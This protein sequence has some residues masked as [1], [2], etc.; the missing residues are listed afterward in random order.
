[1]SSRFVGVAGL[2]R[3]GSTLLCQLLAEHPEIHC[4]GHSSPL[5]NALLA[6]RRFISDDQ[7]MLSQLDV[8]FDKTYQ[9]L[10]SAMQG[11]LKGWYADSGKPVTVD[12]NRAWLHCIEMVLQLDP[13]ARIL[14]P[15]RELGQIYGSIE[16]QHQKTILLDFIDHLADFDRFGRADQ[17]FAADKSIGAPLSSIRAVED[18]PQETKSRLYF[19]KFEDMVANPVETM[20]H[21]FAWLGVSPRKIDPKNLTVRP[22]ESD[23]HYRYKYRHRQQ[24]KFSPPKLHQIPPRIQKRIETA[25]SWYYDWFYPRAKVTRA[26]KP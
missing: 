13:E 3:A 12:K 14:V 16:A 18:L 1:M 26:R 23:S 24:S 5:C 25:C 4:E 2:P 10:R 8:Q 19:V 6:T 21:V 11:F 20:S 17:L 15:I 9:H 7:F 22:H